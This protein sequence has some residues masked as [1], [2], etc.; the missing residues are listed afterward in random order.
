MFALE[1]LSVYPDEIVLIRCP[2]RKSDLIHRHV[3]AGSPQVSQVVIPKYLWHVEE[4]RS[5]LTIILLVIHHRRPLI[6]E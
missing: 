6:L 3:A 2:F 5:E 1:H 4:F